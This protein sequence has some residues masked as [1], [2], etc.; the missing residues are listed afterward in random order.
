MPYK[1][2]FI[3]ISTI[4][5]ELCTLVVMILMYFFIFDTKLSTRITIEAAIIFIVISTLAI[6]FLLSF[7]LLRCSI[8]EAWK[9]IEEARALRFVSAA[10]QI[11][12]M[13]GEIIL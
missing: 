10:T 6:E 4:I 2:T 1:D 8:K 5:R 3:F 9:R 11:T 12:T 7:Y 13:K